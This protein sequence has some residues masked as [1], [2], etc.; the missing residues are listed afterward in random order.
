ME[1]MTQLPLL[2]E[3][4]RAIGLGCVLIR[5]GVAR[6]TVHSWFMLGIP[7]SSMIHI[8]YA[9]AEMDDHKVHSRTRLAKL[10]IEESEAR[11]RLRK[12][13]SASNIPLSRRGIK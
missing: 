3:T 5:F 9:L 4:V 1:K 6:Q 11:K 10:L 13:K 12:S 8:A 7:A 2:T